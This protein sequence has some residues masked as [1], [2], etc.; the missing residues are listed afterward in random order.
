MKPL[1]ILF[2]FVT[3]TITSIAQSP[4]ISGKI[5]DENNEALAYANVLLLHSADST[6]YK[7][8]VI[9][10][11]GTYSFQDINAGDY[12]IN[13][14]LVG[15]GEVYSD[16]ISFDGVNALIVPTLQ[17]SNG[18]EIDQ[19]TV[20]AQKP[21]IELKAD[22][23]IVN[24]ANSAVNAGGTALE[25]IAK[26]PGVIVDNNNRISLRGKQGV[27]VTINGKNQYLSGD[28]LS[29]MLENMPADNIQRM[30][31]ITN[32]SAK[33]DAE[34]NS[35]IINIVLKKNENLGFNGRISTTARQ[36]N[37]F[38]H[39]HNLNLNHRS[40]K[41]H[42]F[43]GIE[44]Y[45]WNKDQQLDL[46]R[47]IPNAEG[48]TTFDQVS[49]FDEGG[50]GYESKVGLNWTVTNKL[51]LGIVARRD[52]DYNFSNIDNITNIS[53][54]NKP[55]FEIL[56]VVNRGSE[57]YTKNTGNANA[58][59]KF[60]EQG[61]TLSFDADYSTYRNPGTYTY[62]NYYLN[63][64]NDEVAPTYFLRNNL[65]TD[66]D[67]FASTLDFTHAIS[68]KL[69]IETGIK[70]GVVETTNTTLFEDLDPQDNW[71]NITTRSNDFM[72]SEEVAA[73]YINGSGAVGN[74]Q[75]Q[76]GLRMEHT[77]SEA[78]SP[79]LGIIVPRSY[80]NYFPS[81]S[82]SRSFENGH[83]ISGTYSRR[84]ERPNYDYLNPFEFYLD[85]YTFRKGNSFI[86]PQYSNAFGL[87][88]AV[89]RKLF[90][91]LNYSHTTDFITSVIE[92]D[93]ENNINFQ[94][95]ANLD[96]YH[97][98][99]WTLSAPKVWSEF[100]TSKFNYT[101]FY[102]RFN[103]VIPSGILSNNNVAHNVSI[104]NEINLPKDWNMELSGRYTSKMV[105]A[106]FQIEPRYSVDAGVSKTVLN[107]LGKIR[108]SITDI[109]KT[110]IS[111][112]GVMQDDIFLESREIYDSRRVSVNFSY[113]FGNQK[114]KSAKRRSTAGSD[115][116]NRI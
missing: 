72:Y 115:E 52:G 37:K 12:L 16:L 111:N 9:N 11:D 61:T 34:G 18:I 15:F 50:D 42:L 87:N 91:A 76:A 67:I 80:T 62:D 73:A 84:L 89:G 20:T 2:A 78:V 88:Y 94:T 102:N 40:E 113:S 28:E 96:D 36:G 116:S 75:L 6:L 22:K 69:Q 95:Q 26:A 107:N 79:T 74:Y 7:G 54:T 68:K 83:N 29:R 59:Y 106:L 110:Q 58:T 63:S 32:P 112:V 55:A 92:Q 24:V 21:F 77:E 101:G 103:S 85:Q 1:F 43:G 53:G 104:Q 93:T 97:N 48:F 81:V 13:S 90:I 46:L 100:A 44:Y 38:S 99:S 114:V 10:N 41:L 49:M 5:I 19:V 25:V 82:I 47:N 33:Y 35:G 8:N 39:F 45:E 98:I 65:N 108:I 14:S 31:V 17:L 51:D 56:D 86:N 27:L 64:E 23:M 71:N 109:F 57:N 70:Y 60:N 30:E 3:T 4:S 66:I 105:Y